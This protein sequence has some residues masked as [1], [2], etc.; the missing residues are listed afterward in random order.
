MNPSALSRHALAA[1]FLLATGTLTFAETATTDPVGFFSKAL[2]VSAGGGARTTATVSVPLYR[3][4]VYTAAATSVTNGS[5]Q[6]TCQLSGGNFGTGVGQTDVTTYPHLMRIKTSTDTTHIGRF[7]EVKAASGDQLSLDDTALASFLSIG[8][9]CEVFPANTL[10]NTFGA[11]TGTGNTSTSTVPAGW[12]TAASAAS[13]DNVF[14][15]NGSWLTFYHNGTNWKQSGSGL[16]KNFTIIYPGEG[17]FVGRIGT[18]PIT[19][20][21]TGTVPTTTE[22]TNVTGSGQTL[23]ANR[24]PV[25]MTLLACHFETIPGWVSGANASAADNVYIYSNGWQTYYYTGTIWKKSGS[26]LDQGTITTIPAGSAV[27]LRR[28]TAGNSTL[29]QNTPY[30]P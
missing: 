2:V 21:T 27:F 28:T 25:D 12:V 15:W 6:S 11:I 20:V 29:T 24:F 5:P 23:V 13:A 30:T 18:T 3:P 1:A 4:P 8:D 10:G 22:R 14:I 19:L 7:F 9:T 16:N 26:G 17:L